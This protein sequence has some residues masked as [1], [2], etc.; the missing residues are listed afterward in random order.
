MST[1]N[2]IEVPVVDGVKAFSAVPVVDGVKA[3]SAALVTK[4]INAIGQSIE[5][6]LA[7]AEWF[8][9]MKKHGVDSANVKTFR[10][11]FDRVCVGY[12]ET[13][14]PGLEVWLI[15]AKDSKGT[16]ESP[17]VNTKGKKYTKRALETLIRTLRIHWQNE[18][19]KSL[20]GETKKTATRTERTIFEQ[21][22][23]AIHPRMVAFQKLETPT[24]Y[25]MD[26]LKL[27]RGVIEHA[28]A[29]DPKAKAEYI[30][31]QAKQSKLIK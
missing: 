27:I 31:L 17:F 19:E 21:D 20:N 7:R 22:V 14:L 3:F 18:F 8:A 12:L 25:Q 26:H 15:G 11:E 4:G 13:K 9:G 29:N 28:I 1:L 5:A 30:S 23:R 24:Q 6:G 16:A 10:P 2:V